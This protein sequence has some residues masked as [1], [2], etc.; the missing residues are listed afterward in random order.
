[1]VREPRTG[2]P[3]RKMKHSPA[4][5]ERVEGL[6][7]ITSQSRC[8]RN[9]RQIPGRIKHLTVVCS[10][11]AKMSPQNCIAILS[12]P[13]VGSSPQKR[14]RSDERVGVKGEPERNSSDACG[15]IDNGRA[16][17]GGKGGK[18][19]GDFSTSD[20]AATA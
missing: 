18:A 10:S 17:G 13:W 2:P 14:R 7:R 9:L 15:A 11:L 20:E 4:R 1:M 19:V 5:P 8:R 12:P 6:E 16:G 3:D